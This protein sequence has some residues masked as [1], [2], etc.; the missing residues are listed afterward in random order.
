MSTDRSEYVDLSNVRASLGDFIDDIDHTG[1]LDVS[2]PVG[3]L[4]V[5]RDG[6]DWAMRLYGTG[7]GFCWSE[8]DVSKRRIGRYVAHYRDAGHAIELRRVD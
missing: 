5:E 2:L 1:R 3:T 4:Q 8:T 7:G 6:A